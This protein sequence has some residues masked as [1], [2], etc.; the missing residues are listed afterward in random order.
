M[1]DLFAIHRL[2][3]T[4]LLAALIAAGAFIAI[5]LPLSPVPVTLQTLFIVLA[6]LILG[7][8]YGVFAVLL[9]IIAGA[10]GLPIFSGGKGG[11]GVLF[12]PTGGY[13]AGFIVSV[14]ISA[15]AR[16]LSLLPA[17]L[18]CFV[19]LMLLLSLGSLRLAQVLNIPVSQGFA[20]GLVPFVPG[21]ILK[22]FCALAIF[23]FLR[24]NRLLPMDYQR[25][26]D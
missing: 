8:K 10:F 23:K 9:Y 18:L 22:T 7:P 14:L 17:N 21:G 19:G 16:N 24:A 6:G 12:G 4:A 20:L 26:Y 5:P 11:V 2:V 13:F 15:K 25:P 1:S 3:W